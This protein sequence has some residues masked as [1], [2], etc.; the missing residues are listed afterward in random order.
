MDKYK[1]IAFINN[2]A[3]TREQLE[4]LE[5]IERSPDN[6]RYYIR[7]KNLYAAGIAG[8]ERRATDRDFAEFRNIRKRAF[9]RKREFHIPRKWCVIGIT[10]SI[11]A[12][13]AILGTLLVTNRTRIDSQSDS[14]ISYHTPCGVKGEVTLPDGSV[15]M[16][17][18]ASRISFPARFSGNFREVGFCG[19]GYFKVI[20]NPGLPMRIRSSNGVVLEVK[21]TEFNLSCYPDDNTVRTSLYSGVLSVLSD[22]PSGHRRRDKIEPNETLIIHRDKKIDGKSKKEV[23]PAEIKP[24]SCD[25]AAWKRG[26][27]IFD[28]DPMT[29]VVKKLQRWH[30]VEFIINDDFILR[31]NLS[32]RFKSESIPQIMD[33]IRMAT[34]INYSIQDN[35]V[36]LFADDIQIL[37]PSLGIVNK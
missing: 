10:A 8:S 9:K 29:E 36:T 13:I 11:A 15:V 18:S 20:S 14:L 34:G 19:E 27:I 17:N 28:D 25:E 26:E 5:W 21:G 35:K 37:T 23:F 12:V 30:G 6:R 3:T 33:M 16:L 7:L 32:A 2:N 24:L 4:V 1:I 31:Q 22:D